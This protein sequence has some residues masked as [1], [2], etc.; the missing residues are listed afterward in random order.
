LKKTLFITTSFLLLSLAA[1]AQREISVIPKAGVVFSNSIITFN[2]Q[3]VESLKTRSSYAFGLY[4]RDIEKEKFIIT[5]GI[6][7][8]SRGDIAILSDSAVSR[9]ENVA[10]YVD[11]PILVGFQPSKKFFQVKGGIQFSR[12][13][14]STIQTPLGNANITDAFKAWDVAAL[15]EISYEFDFGLNLTARYSGGITNYQR[16]PAFFPNPAFV[17]ETRWVNF[18]ILAGYSL[19]IRF[20]RY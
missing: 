9:V 16:E 20:G 17:Y 12:L 18:Q 13:V 7:Y 1:F 11:I 5:T 6:Q 14:N 3:V 10:D 2:E 4:L 19:P 8:S 15:L